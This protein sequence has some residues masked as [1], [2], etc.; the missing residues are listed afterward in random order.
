MIP[1]SV[2]REDRR[3]GGGFGK[4]KNRFLIIGGVNYQTCAR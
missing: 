4:G 1:V 2:R 3:H